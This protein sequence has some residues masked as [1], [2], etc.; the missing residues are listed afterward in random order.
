MAVVVI[1]DEAKATARRALTLMS[2]ALKPIEARSKASSHCYQC[3]D[4]GL[5]LVQRQEPTVSSL[6]KQSLKLSDALLGIK[7]L[8]DHSLVDEDLAQA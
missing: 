5:D 1:T 3:L 2:K 4:G 7:T 8:Q 6:L